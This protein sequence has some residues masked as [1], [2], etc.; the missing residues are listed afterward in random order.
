MHNF[1]FDFISTQSY[2]T[3]SQSKIELKQTEPPN[4][5]DRGRGRGRANR[6]FHVS[7]SYN[8]VSERSD[9]HNSGI[10]SVRARRDGNRGQ[11]PLLSRFQQFT[12]NQCE[13]IQDDHIKSR[14]YDKI[15][16]FGI[17]PPEL[18]HVFSTLASY[19]RFCYVGN[20]AC[21]EAQMKRELDPD[22]MKCHWFDGFSRRVHIREN[23]LHEVTVHVEQ[24][25]TELNA[26]PQPLTDEQDFR[27]EMNRS[28]LRMINLH[29]ADERL[30]CEP[31]RLLKISLRDFIYDDGKR[32]PPIPVF[33]QINPLHTHQFI[34][35]FILSSG[36][37][38]TEKDAFSNPSIRECFAKTG[39]IG[40]DT[41]EVSLK[42]DINKLMREKYIKG[43]L[44]Y[45]SVSLWKAQ[46]FIS[47]VWR[48]LQDVIL[49]DSIPMFEIPFTTSQ[50]ADQTEAKNST[51]WS[52]M[53]V[54]MIEAMRAVV[55]YKENLPSD[56]SL[57]NATLNDPI[58]W[59]PHETMELA[60]SQTEESLI[61][62]KEVMSVIVNAVDKYCDPVRGR[63]VTTQAKN[64]IVHGAPGTGKS[65]TGTCAM[66][67]C[68]SQ[69]L[70]VV[71]TAVMAVRASQFGGPNFHRLIGLPVNKT[72]QP[73]R[74]AELALEKI[75]RKPELLY[76]LL[77]LNVIFI[78]EIGQISAGQVST[79][80][81]V[82]R[83][84]RK[85]SMLYGG[86]LLIGTMDHAQLAPINAIPFLMS[87]HLITSYTLVE[88]KQSVRASSDPEFQKFQRIIRMN[89]RLLL[90]NPVLKDDFYRLGT[91][92]FTYVPDWNDPAI[93]PTAKRM[94]ARRT[95]VYLAHQ[96]WS[97]SVKARFERDGMPFLTRRAE[98]LQVHSG[99]HSSWTV[100]SEQTTTSLNVKCREPDELL[101]YRGALFEVTTNDSNNAYFHADRVLLYELP[102]ADT[103]RSFSP[104]PMLRAPSWMDRFPFLEEDESE[105]N[106][107][108]S[109]EELLA[110]GWE[111]VRIK[112]A[113]EREE[114]VH[115]GLRATRKQYAIRCTLASTVDKSQG[116]TFRGQTVVEFTETNCP[117]LK[118]H[119]VVIFSRTIN[120]SL[121]YIVGERSFVLDRMW[122]L[123]TTPTQWTQQMERT[124]EM[125]TINNRSSFDP[126][127]YTM[128][129]RDVYPFAV[130]YYDLPSDHTGYVYILCSQRDPDWS[131]VGETDDLKRRLR[132][133]QQPGGGSSG[134]ADMSKHPV[135]YAGYIAGLGH[136]TVSERKSLERELKDYVKSRSG[137]TGPL[138]VCAE[139]TR[140]VSNHNASYAIRGMNERMMFV[141]LIER[142]V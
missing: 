96:E 45:Y 2:E 139:A 59:S 109:K 1:Q 41:S 136:L 77:T 37:Y 89:P 64:I 91:E 112:V 13:I 34:V 22:L 80:D 84:V 108:P 61:E 117:W 87:S 102:D 114:F 9:V 125:L 121:L 44:V 57:M 12:E 33:S 68:M 110:S 119:I 42:R 40:N 131:Y 38:V 18:V 76:V 17:R 82:L 48:L 130:K 27:L 29:H 21:D 99:T 30:L 141:S 106:P 88:L 28:V 74:A 133:H 19:F 51:Y 65:W 85:N 79:L 39:L 86:V 98:D 105:T 103:L 95:N 5:S 56:S 50:S 120:A 127:D 31:D 53:K 78:D 135:S 75:M 124:L 118:T 3:R 62:Q 15:S 94:Y 137:K 7:G 113:P 16:E 97:K 116:A 132:Q 72:Y 104:I 93:L 6:D 69:G 10:A 63:E 140:L 26:H 32:H 4:F 111:E 11:Y 49:H 25:I 20:E 43:S 83:T 52:D 101:F 81:V 129:I 35:H 24:N 107:F 123:I 23:A 46:S 36:R 58:D 122:T 92:L 47:R 70:R 71:P 14:K 126:E 66:M 138:E 115:S 8:D 90:S 73:M 128:N 142:Q 60:D 55:G 100:A 134:T 67:Y 54:K